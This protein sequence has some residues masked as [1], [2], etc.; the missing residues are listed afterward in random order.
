[1]FNFERK[2]DY[3]KKKPLATESLIWGVVFS[4][5]WILSSESKKVECG[6]KIL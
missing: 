5:N 3:I 4:I 6:K 1:M 2:G